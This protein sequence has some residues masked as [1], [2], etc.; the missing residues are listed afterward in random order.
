MSHFVE[1]KAYTTGLIFLD[2][3]GWVDGRMVG[4]VVGWKD[5]WMGGDEGGTTVGLTG[6]DNS[7]VRSLWTFT[8]CNL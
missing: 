1:F 6:C 3:D 2:I 4:W 7:L 5:G 8:A